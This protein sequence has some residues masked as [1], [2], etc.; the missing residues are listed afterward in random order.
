MI[1]DEIPCK[2]QKM[3]TEMKEMLDA[4]YHESAMSQTNVYR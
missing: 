1:R 3:V 4:C 2:A